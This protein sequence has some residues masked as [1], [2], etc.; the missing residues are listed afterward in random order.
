MAVAHPKSKVFSSPSISM[1]SSQLWLAVRRSSVRAWGLRSTQ[2]HAFL[3][4][5]AESLRA[6][7]SKCRRSAILP[8]MATLLQDLSD[9]ITVAFALLAL[10]TMADWIRHR[11][12]QRIFLVVAL[13]SLALLALMAPLAALVRAPDPVVADAS[14]VLFLLSGYALLMFRNALLPLG[15]RTRRGVTAAV[16]AVGLLGVAAG[17][18]SDR[19]AARG[20]F[21]VA[22][23]VLLVL[24]WVLCIAEPMFRFGLLSV[25]RPAVEGSRLRALSLGYGG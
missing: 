15:V 11:D 12:R 10:A 20:V 1:N 17:L 2:P 25:G 3:R 24:T 18:S 19:S 5:R 21:Q 4:R 16:I 7:S 9:A 13:V 14:I 8:R 22:V 23:T 6:L